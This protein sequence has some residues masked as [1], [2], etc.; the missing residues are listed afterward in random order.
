M[1]VDS[2]IKVEPGTV[3]P[4]EYNWQE[5]FA[6]VLNDNTEPVVSVDTGKLRGL[7]L[8]YVETQQAVAILHKERTDLIKTVAELFNKNQEMYQQLSA[9]ESKPRP[10][11]VGDRVKV[12]KNAGFNRGAMGV[13]QFIEPTDGGK[14]WVLRDRSSSPVWYTADELELIEE[15]KNE[16]N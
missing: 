2:L 6:E 7:V 5:Q 8:S 11:V 1:D 14:V 9:L 16:N 13:I 12:R 3:W 10:F 15:L 4:Y